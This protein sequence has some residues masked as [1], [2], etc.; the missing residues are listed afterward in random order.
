MHAYVYLSSFSVIC[1]VQPVMCECACLLLL[2]VALLFVVLTNSF[3]QV[4]YSLD[5]VKI[6]SMG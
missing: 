1:I 3:T 5:K 6:R 4:F 2:S